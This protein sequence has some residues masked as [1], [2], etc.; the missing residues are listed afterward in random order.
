MKR[1][2]LLRH[3]KSDWAGKS[4][5]DHSRPISTRGRDDAKR[6]G[7]WMMENNLLPQQIISSDAFRT[8]QTVELLTGQWQQAVDIQFTDLLY[9]AGYKTM[10]ELIH[11]TPVTV[12]SLMLVAHNPGMDDMVTFLSDN[13]PPVTDE[14]K[15]MATC[16]L[17]IFDVAA[18][19]SDIAKHSLNLRDIARPKSLP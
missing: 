14:G 2:Y 7:K 8:Q 11:S 6:L 4:G 12:Q 5:S 9:L 3:A 10:L 17:A 15:L 19:W 16:N 13:A 1:L 18:S